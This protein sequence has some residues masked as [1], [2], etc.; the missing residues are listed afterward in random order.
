M[1][2]EKS[3]DTFE[4]GGEGSESIGIAEDTCEG[5][6]EGGE[7]TY[8]GGQGVDTCLGGDLSHV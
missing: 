4:E 3:E 5:G 8:K 7:V 1:K 6:G 2:V